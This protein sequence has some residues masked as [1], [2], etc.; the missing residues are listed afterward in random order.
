MVN[1]QQQQ[2]VII[3]YDMNIDFYDC[4]W[5]ICIYESE[6]LDSKILIIIII[7]WS[8]LMWYEYNITINFE[9][10]KFYY[11]QRTTQTNDRIQ[12][13]EYSIENKQHQTLRMMEKKFF[14]SLLFQIFKKFDFQT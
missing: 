13:S 9:W 11:T 2:K 10:T 6:I 14:F 12:I 5:W 1:Q 3:W 8:D 7:N 4:V